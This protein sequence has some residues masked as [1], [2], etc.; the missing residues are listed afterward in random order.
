[1]KKVRCSD[2]DAAYGKATGPLAALPGQEACAGVGTPHKGHSWST[3]MSPSV[4]NPR[5]AALAT[6]SRFRLSSMP[7]F[8]ARIH[9]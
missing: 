1:M 9:R 6:R 2:V 7:G 3:K 5:E 8:L 4:L